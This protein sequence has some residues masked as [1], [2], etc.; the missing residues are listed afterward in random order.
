MLDN[1][2]SLDF[3]VAEV[4]CK[5]FVRLAVGVFIVV[6][7]STIIIVLDKSFRDKKADKL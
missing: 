3:S 5:F 2:L 7:S 4:E 6:L 1:C